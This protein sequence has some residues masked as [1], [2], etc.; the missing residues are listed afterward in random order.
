MYLGYK[1]CLIWLQIFSSRM[2]LKFWCYLWC[3]SP[4]CVCLMLINLSFPWSLLNFNSFSK[5]LSLVPNHKHFPLFSSVIFGKSNEFNC[6]LYYSQL[7]GPGD[8]ETSFLDSAL[9]AVP[10]RIISCSQTNTAKVLD[11]LGVLPR[12]L[13][14]WVEPTCIFWNL[15]RAAGHLSGGC[16]TSLHLA[17]DGPKDLP[18]ELALRVDRSWHT[19]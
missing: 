17:E 4:S 1:S 2:L 7:R 10:L 5:K 18:G 8:L 14:H 9:P 15:L 13:L 19:G 11:A 12:G 16:L 6:H 3:F